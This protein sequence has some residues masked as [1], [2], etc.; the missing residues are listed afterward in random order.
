MNFISDGSPELWMC[1][2]A[3]YD[4]EIARD[5]CEAAI[6]RRVHPLKAAVAA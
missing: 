4:L 5:R 6:I 2:Q 3:D 1:I